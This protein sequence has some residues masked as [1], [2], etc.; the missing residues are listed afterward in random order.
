MLKIGGKATLIVPQQIAY[1]AE[2]KGQMIPP[3]STII[4]EVEL[5]S[6]RSKEA[7]DKERQA[8]QAQQQLIEDQRKNAEKTER[9]NYIRE[10]GIT[11]APTASGLY[12]IET[13][14]G[15]GKKA[16][17]GNTVNVHYT[18]RLLDGT[19]FD[20]S[21]EKGEPFSFRLGGGQVIK[22]WDEAI[23]L[24]SEGG[25]ATLVIPSEIA[26]GS[27]NSGSIPPYS[28]LVFDVELV[29]VEETQ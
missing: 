23:A 8:K 6:M 4:Y 12:Y 17:P 18:G 14:K 1:G 20:S 28:T 9:D 27:R 19:V 2:A 3:Y 10:N 26:Y 7:Y 5:V 15:E 16:M 22:G 13:E 24:M 29:S 25:K 11:V 21:V